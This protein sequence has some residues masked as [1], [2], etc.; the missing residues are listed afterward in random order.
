[1][2]KEAMWDPDVFLHSIREKALTASMAELADMMTTNWLLLRGS[3]ET[4]AR[5]GAFEEAMDIL[6]AEVQTRKDQDDDQP[7]GEDD[8]PPPAGR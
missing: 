2:D 4:G 5:D 3:Q 7:G 1:M 6:A 8:Q